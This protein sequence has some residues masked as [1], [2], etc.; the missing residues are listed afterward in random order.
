MIWAYALQF[1]SE[2]ALFVDHFGNVHSKTEVHELGSTNQFK[3]E[4]Q[5]HVLIERKQ[6]YKKFESNIW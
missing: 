5:N 4:I 1:L 2:K 6:V 3:K